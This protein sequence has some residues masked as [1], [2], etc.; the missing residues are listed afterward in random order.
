[1]GVELFRRFVTYQGHTGSSACL[2]K[3]KLVL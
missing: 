1:M 2:V 3:L